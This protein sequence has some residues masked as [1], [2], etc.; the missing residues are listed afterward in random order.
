MQLESTP[1][2]G[3]VDVRPPLLVD[4]AKAQAL[5]KSFMSS[6]ETHGRIGVVVSLALMLALGS[7]ADTAMSSLA[8]AT[9]SLL[10]MPR[11]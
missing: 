10:A 3:Q 9:A 8:A 1:G 2:N 5:V 4:G 11:H 6:T 7:L